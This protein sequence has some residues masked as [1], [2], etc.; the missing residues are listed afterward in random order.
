VDSEAVFSPVP[1]ITE[2]ELLAIGDLIFPASA[3][4]NV[5][6][7]CG[8]SG[9]LSACPVTPR[10][11]QRLQGAHA[12]LCRCQNP[13]QTRTMTASAGS[14][15]GTIQVA[16]YNGT[17]TYQLAV[18]RENGRLLVDDQTCAGGGADTS[19]Y[20]SLAPCS[21]LGSA[22][23]PAGGS[24]PPVEVPTPGPTGIAA[25]DRTMT[26]VRSGNVH[27]V[28]ALAHLELKGCSTA[29]GLGGPPACRPAEAA[30]TLVSALY[31]SSCDGSYVRED[32]VEPLMQRFLEGQ[33][34]LVG[35]YR[36]TGSSR[37]IPS[38]PFILVYSFA[39]PQGSLGRVL[40]VSDAGI[41]GVTFA[42]GSTA[43]EWIELQELKDAVL[44]PGG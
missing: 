12:T 27:E 3:S 15:G 11:A 42:C 39:T 36:H 40:F 28:A 29:A 23:S 38:S 22:P 44:L 20:Q 21:T 2:Q 8:L 33:G 24:Q 43:K 9:D 13:S 17:I 35:V 4:G 1:Q 25:V 10:L 5:F 34:K 30:G 26:A 31:T 18:V 7:V 6:G 32:G 16:L 37:L 19:I 41:E 14:V